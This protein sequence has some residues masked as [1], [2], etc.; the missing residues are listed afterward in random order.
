MQ[1]RPISSNR[2]YVFFIELCFETNQDVGIY[3]FKN[4]GNLVLWPVSYLESA[5]AG[6]FSLA[7]MTERQRKYSKGVISI[8]LIIKKQSLTRL[9]VIHVILWLIFTLASER[10]RCFPCSINSHAPYKWSGSFKANWMLVCKQQMPQSASAHH[11]TPFLFLF[12]TGVIS[13][14]E[15]RGSQTY[16][17]RPY[18]NF[19]YFISIKN[20]K[21][22][23]A[24]RKIQNNQD[25]FGL[26][27]SC[28]IYFV[29]LII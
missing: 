24:Y 6:L 1:E 9:F 23:A 10:V 22:F 19:N 14:Q 8:M 20:Y 12:Y 3:Y 28:G 15:V 29:Y 21:K 25:C 2:C 16:M 27:W 18:I 26:T 7:E 5:S 17:Y 13:R 4:V 11:N